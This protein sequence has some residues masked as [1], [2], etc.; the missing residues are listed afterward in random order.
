M[1]RW[2]RKAMRT[3]VKR[4]GHALGDGLV[5]R[6]PIKAGALGCWLHRDAKGLSGRLEFEVKEPGQ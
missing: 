3:V 6:N 5:C 2:R 4:C 1:G